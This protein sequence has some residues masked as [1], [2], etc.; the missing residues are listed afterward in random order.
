M[1]LF[2]RFLCFDAKSFLLSLAGLGG[3]MGLDWPRQEF[4]LLSFDFDSRMDR[5]YCWEGLTWMV[6]LVP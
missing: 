2:K 1:S 3:L 5:L 4:M 6:L